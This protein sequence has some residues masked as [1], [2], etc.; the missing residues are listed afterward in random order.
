MCDNRKNVSSIFFFPFSV[1]THTQHLWTVCADTG[2]RR[3]KENEAWAPLI[4]LSHYMDHTLIK[5]KERKLCVVHNVEKNNSGAWAVKFLTLA[6]SHACERRERKNLWAVR[7]P[8]CC[9]HAD[10][11]RPAACVTP[12][13]AHSGTAAALYS[14]THTAHNLITFSLFFTVWMWADEWKNGGVRLFPDKFLNSFSFSLTHRPINFL[15]LFLLY[16]WGRWREKR[17]KNS[18]GTYLFI[19]F[20]GTKTVTS[21]PHQTLGPQKIVNE[22]EL[23][24]AQRLGLAWSEGLDFVHR[25]AAQGPTS[26]SLFFFFFILIGPHIVSL[27]FLY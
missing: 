13:A 22:K 14:F 6:A 10:A 11:N 8:P 27:S 3:E 19:T 9:W 4:I 17:K 18:L 24:V 12:Y 25:F 15:L 16:L 23:D 2:E 1:S 5:R 20:S 26:S 21:W 7:L